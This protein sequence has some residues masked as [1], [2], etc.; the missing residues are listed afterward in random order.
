MQELSEISAIFLISSSEEM[1]YRKK[2]K[3][4]KNKKRIKG[5]TKK[6]LAMLVGI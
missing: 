5:R 2:Y 6:L 4:Q 3:I 1:S